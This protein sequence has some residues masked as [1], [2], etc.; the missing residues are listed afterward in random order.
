MVMTRYGELRELED[1][2]VPARLGKRKQKM[3]DD[4]PVPSRV[5][6]LTT[7]AILARLETQGVTTDPE[8][9]RSAAANRNSAWTIG[10]E[11]V[12]GLKR[13][14]DRDVR[15]FLGL[16]ACE[17]WK[18]WI[19][20][21]PSVEM[22][23]DRMQEGYEA[24]AEGDRKQCDIWLPVWSTLR[25]WITPDMRT[26]KKAEAVFS[27]SQYLFN[28]LQD[29]SMALHNAALD[30]RVYADHGIEFNR[31]VLDQF[32]E[33]SADFLRSF[34][35][36]LVFLYFAKG[37]REEGVRLAREIIEADPTRTAAYVELADGLV[38]CPP[39]SGFVPD[40]EGAI[41]ALEEAAA[42]PVT[43]GDDYDLDL[44]LEELRG[45]HRG[46]GGDE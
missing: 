9:F 20:E 3:L 11:W 33:E 30:D 19:A 31:A 43:D 17:L 5:A 46:G 37:R 45:A 42:A 41:A 28:W 29:L 34:A 26:V 14:V 7:E 1:L 6:A 16:A 18:R 32:V 4:L 23:D 12:R 10:E 40:Y 21:R 44:R 39:G 8:Q 25:G 13:L 22:L 15:D 24:V 36:E 27:G 38:L 35:C 2:A